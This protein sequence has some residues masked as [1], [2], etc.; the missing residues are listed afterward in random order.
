MYE[1]GRDRGNPYLM[2]K[3]CSGT[4]TNG[5]TRHYLIFLIKHYCL[6]TQQPLTNTTRIS[7]L[8]TKITTTELNGIEKS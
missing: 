8:I 6:D 7:L 3:G 5:T 2:D 4:Y 1:W